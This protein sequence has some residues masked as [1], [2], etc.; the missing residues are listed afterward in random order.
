M[1]QAVTDRRVSINAVNI[2]G[3]FLIMLHQMILKIQRVDGSLLYDALEL[4]FNMAAKTSIL[5]NSNVD[6]LESLN[7]KAYVSNVNTH[8]EITNSDIIYAS[9][10]NSKAD[11]ST[12]YTKTEIKAF[13]ET[14]YTFTLPF[15]RTVDVTTEIFTIGINSNTPINNTFTE[16]IDIQPPSQYGGSIRIIPALDNNGASIGYY[17]YMDTRWTS[18]GDA[19]VCGVNC[20]DERVCTIAT[21]VLNTCFNINLSG[22]VN[23][24]YGLITPAITVNHILEIML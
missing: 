20:G 23:I 11:K 14:Q 24:P 2:D 22:N 8:Q 9:A 16:R 18:V 10:L 5:K 19:W 12:S 21:P 6:I 3:M 15:T 17:E 13:I 7:L 4:S 1:L